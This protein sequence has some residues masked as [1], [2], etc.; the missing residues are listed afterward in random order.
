[1]VAGD[2]GRRAAGGDPPGVR[3]QDSGQEVQGAGLEQGAACATCTAFYHAW[4]T[5]GARGV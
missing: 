1:M 4:H 2:Q 5:C 3:R